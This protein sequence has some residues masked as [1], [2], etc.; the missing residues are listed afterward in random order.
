MDANK[1]LIGLLVVFLVLFIICSVA[2]KKS[3]AVKEGYEDLMWAKD[4]AKGNWVSRPNFRADLSPRFDAERVGG[5]NI[6]GTFPG[7]A[8]QGA[9]LTPVES[10]M[11]VSTPSYA[12]MGGPNAAYGDSRLPS[13]GMTTSQVNSILANKFGRGNS[14]APVYTD[15][16]QLLPTADMKKAL[17]RDPS[18]ASTFMFDRYIFAPLKR[19]YGKVQTDFIRGDLAIPQLRMGWFDPNPVARQDLTQGYF[20][21][22]LDIQQNTSIKDAI[23]ER[24][25]TVVQKEIPWSRLA[26]RTVYSVL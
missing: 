12:A 4:Y 6:V 10:V 14:D 22:Y 9:P 17:A 19:R 2:S 5:G 26:E 21:D 7:M 20:S 3:I 8:V 15:P 16:K 24:K 11:S 13:G 25:P 1:V 23:F 18:D